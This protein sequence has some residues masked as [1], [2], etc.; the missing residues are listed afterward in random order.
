[1]SRFFILIAAILLTSGCSKEKT[2]SAS[3]DT[4]LVAS[5]GASE[6]F[7][8]GVK[9]VYT[10]GTAQFETGVWVL[11]NALVGTSSL[12]HKFDHKAIRITGDGRLTSDFF[13]TNGV[14]RVKI[15]HAVYGS[16]APSEWGLFY[17][18][19]LDTTWIEVGDKVISTSQKLD[20]TI[21]LV[22]SS[23]SV[24]LQIR[25]LSGGDN[26]I[27]IDDITYSDYSAEIPSLGAFETFEG[28]VKDGYES[29]SV[30]FPSG[31]WTLDDAV[32]GSTTQDRKF[33]HSSIRI[34]NEGKVT[35]N[36]DFANGVGK[37]TLYHGVYGNDG[38]STWQLFYSIDGGNSWYSAGNA[39]ESNT[40]NMRKAEF[41]VN[42]EGDVR[43]QI[44]KIS[45]GENQINIDDLSY[46]AYSVDN[47]SSV[48]TRDNNMTMGNPSNATASIDSFS[49]YF[50]ERAEYSLSYN[51]D[52]GTPNWVSWHLSSAWVGD[53][54]RPS[55]FNTDVTLPSGWYRVSTSDYTNT[56]FDRGHLCPASD[57]DFTDA[58][59][60]NTFIMTN[61]MPQAPYNNQQPWRLLEEYC[62]TLADA[63]DEMYIIAG[64]YGSGGSGSNGGVTTTIASGK[65]TV[66]SYTWK[67]ILVLPNGDNDVARVNVNTRVIAVWVP[68]T[69][70]GLTTDWSQYRTSVDYIESQTGYDFFSNVPKAIQ[71]V[72]EAKTDTG[73][74]H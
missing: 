72:I 3:N 4:T 18:T 15:Y 42:M 73:P 56:G 9:D 53:A 16:D 8:N 33:D 12:D 55:Y 54:P 58:E 23:G 71:A 20:S 57:R 22:N 69:H 37:V 10:L 49:N 47:G 48:A 68:N 14:G 38:P 70:T 65:V 39:V 24:K 17:S 34:R 13:F 61:V 43:L 63:G 21:F 66:P 27:D 51:R 25:K 36:F 67:V 30:T 60:K 7:E 1:M 31:S 11:D 5:L 28:A 45:G 59:I 19:L 32:V 74:S 6:N 50:M 52:K 62:R 29:G 64:P 35:S 41:S 40:Y 26:R 2:S 44:R 46:T